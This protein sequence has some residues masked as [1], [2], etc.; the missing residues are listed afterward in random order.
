MPHVNRR[1]QKSY[2]YHITSRSNWK[3]PLFRSDDDFVYFLQ[4]LDEANKKYPF[5]LVSYVLMKTHFHLLLFSN[6]QSYSNIMFLEKKK[7]ATFFNK[8]YNTRG[9]LFEKRFFAKP[10]STPRTLLHMS[11]Y[12]HFNP[13]EIHSVESPKDYQWSSYPLFIQSSENSLTPPY[14]NFTPLL[15]SFTGTYHQRKMQYIQWCNT[16]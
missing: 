3:E 13:V 4:L 2:Y 15:R 12:I 14:I 9:H 5:Q 1:W 6:T 11:R 16:N 8:K 7:Y 10:A